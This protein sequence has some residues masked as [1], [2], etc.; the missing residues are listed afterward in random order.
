MATSNVY[1]RQVSS[2]IVPNSSGLLPDPVT[3]TEIRGEMRVLYATLTFVDADAAGA[4]NVAILPKNA[5]ILDA[6]FNVVNAL[7]AGNSELGDSGDADRFIAAVST[8]S[9]G[10]AGSIA[11][12]GFGYKLTADTT[13]LFTTAANPVDGDQVD[14]YMMY[15]LD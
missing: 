8:A 14:V 15:V 4:Y 13:I 5:R 9:T 2:G 3:P 11:D 1:D 6:K 10:V 12:T 7:A